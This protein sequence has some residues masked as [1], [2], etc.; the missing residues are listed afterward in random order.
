MSRHERQ[1][2]EGRLHLC[3]WEDGNAL[4]PGGLGNG[5]PGIFM[6]ETEDGEIG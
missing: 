1:R 5:L 4:P 3:A 6:S 2:C